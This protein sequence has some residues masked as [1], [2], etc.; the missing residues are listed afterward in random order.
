MMDAQILATNLE[1]G[2]AVDVFGV[3]IPRRADNVRLT[4]EVV[5]N[6]FTDFAV[7]SWRRCAENPSW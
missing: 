2:S 4:V 3:W 7:D 1:S 5:H 6:Y